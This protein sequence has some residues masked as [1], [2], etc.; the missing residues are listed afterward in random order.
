MSTS[1]GLSGCFQPGQAKIGLG[2]TPLERSVSVHLH[3][4]DC[5][6]A[7]QCSPDVLHRLLGA[8]SDK[9]SEGGMSTYILHLSGLTQWVYCSVRQGTVGKQMKKRNSFVLMKEPTRFRKPFGFCS[10][11]IIIL[12]ASHLRGIPGCPPAGSVLCG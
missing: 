12:S 5:S 3:S 9:I 7:A 1:T 10:V 6:L 4:V 11:Y 8:D 2:P